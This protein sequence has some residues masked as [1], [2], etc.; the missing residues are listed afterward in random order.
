[1]L[2]ESVS[3]TH[4]D[5]KILY[6]GTIEDDLLIMDVEVTTKPT[7]IN[8]SDKIFSLGIPDNE[9]IEDFEE[10]MEQLTRNSN[11]DFE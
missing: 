3:Q 6:K 4:D 2:I 5:A 7:K 10:D 9:S 1:M 8:E 11:K